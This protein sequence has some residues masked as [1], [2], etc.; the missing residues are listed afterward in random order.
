LGE[1]KPVTDEAELICV[2][3]ED[4]ALEILA[5]TDDFEDTDF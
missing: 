2:L 5:S 3:A 4:S 1:I